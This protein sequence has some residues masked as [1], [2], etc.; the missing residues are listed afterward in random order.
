[1]E[2][3]PKNMLPNGFVQNGDESHGKNPQKIT[4]NKQLQVSHFQDHPFC[5]SDY[6]WIRVVFGG[7]K[8][9]HGFAEKNP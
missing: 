4:L 9:L 2:K 3:N 8:F 6:V 1:L 5:S 7:C